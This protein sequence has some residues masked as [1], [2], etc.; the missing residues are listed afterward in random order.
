MVK[1]LPKYFQNIDSAL[2]PISEYFQQQNP[3]DKNS[4]IQM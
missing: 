3:S 4:Q 1:E 2:K